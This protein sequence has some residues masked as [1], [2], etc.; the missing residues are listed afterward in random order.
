MS[1]SAGEVRVPPSALSAELLHMRNDLETES[2]FSERVVQL[3]K[4]VTEFRRG[5][6]A[7]AVSAE[8]AVAS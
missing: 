1:A 5:D 8:L 4:F 2:L 3:R 6:L 7:R